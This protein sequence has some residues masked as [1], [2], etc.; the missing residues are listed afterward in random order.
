MAYEVETNIDQLIKTV[1]ADVQGMFT[2]PEMESSGRNAYDIMYKNVRNRMKTTG[3]NYLQSGDFLEAM[4]DE[5]KGFDKENRNKNSMTVGF[6]L[7]GEGLGLNDPSYMRQEQNAT[8]YVSHGHLRGNFIYMHLKA[9]TQMP[10]WVV[11]EFGTKGKGDG[12]P[13]QFKINYSPRP[14][15]SIMFGPSKSVPTGLNKKV[16]M[17]VNPENHAKVGNGKWYSKG[18]E[19]NFSEDVNQHPGVRAGRFFRNG[20]EDSKLPI[21]EE[22]G[23]GLKQYFNRISGV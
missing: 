7:I 13:D 22:L 15:K 17:M 10:K 20:L 8:F 18:D 21:Y 3:Y 12:V 9:E 11:L 4:D 23:K 16:Y 6:G 1:R 19:S 5:R 2:S 14:D